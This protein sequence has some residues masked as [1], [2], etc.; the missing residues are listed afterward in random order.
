MTRPPST[1]TDSLSAVEYWSPWKL[2]E[3]DSSIL[4]ARSEVCLTEHQ[5]KTR[6]KY[7]D[8][9]AGANF[10]VSGKLPEGG[11]FPF[12]KAALFLSLKSNQLWSAAKCWCFK[13][14]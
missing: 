14:Q 10:I 7:V 11:L 1:R 13:M 9:D 6:K 3:A 2:S 8:V 5:M 12:H 4:E